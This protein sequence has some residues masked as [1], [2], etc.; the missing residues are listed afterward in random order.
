MDGRDDDL[1]AE[2]ERVMAAASVYPGVDF[3]AGRAALRKAVEA[4]PEG[5]R[6]ARAL[7]A[8]GGP[9]AAP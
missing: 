7:R 9:E 1:A 4:T 8:F 5:E 3:S 2:V 6:R